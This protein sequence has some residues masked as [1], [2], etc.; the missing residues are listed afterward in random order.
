MTEP[1]GGV[2]FNPDVGA[3]EAPPIAEARRWIRPDAELPLIDVTQAVPG[4]PP[5]TELVAHLAEA[6]TEAE[7]AGY[8]EIEGIA[9]LRAA[10]AAHMAGC[11]GG[12]LEA[13]QVLITAGCNQAFFLTALTWRGP[14]TIFCCRCPTTS[15]TA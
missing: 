9:P 14:A 4:Y 11:Y 7:T 1:G 10:L 3:I 5:A 13:S 6:V 8:T 12:P 2:P 15:I